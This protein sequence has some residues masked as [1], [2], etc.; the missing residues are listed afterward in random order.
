VSLLV[1]AVRTECVIQVQMHPQV[2]YQAPVIL[3]CFPRLSLATNADGKKE[4][5]SNQ[6]ISKRSHCNIPVLKE[7]S[8]PEYMVYF[9]KC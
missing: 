8:D 1:V 4:N 7:P 2:L 5:D 3:P 9:I 6:Q